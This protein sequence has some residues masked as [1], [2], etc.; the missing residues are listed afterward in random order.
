MAIS[1][2]TRRQ[3][4]GLIEEDYIR[5][6]IRCPV[7]GRK[8]SHK[9]L[10]NNTACVDVVCMEYQTTSQVKT[11]SLAK[12]LRLPATVLG[13]SWKAKK[14]FLLEE[15]FHPYFFVFVTSGTVFGVCYLPSACQ[16]LDFLRYASRFQ[17]RLSRR[18]G[19]VNN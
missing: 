16:T 19:L 5:N 2:P 14:K 17:I 12:S 15:V 18:A 3:S 7:C 4:L 10:A 9:L 1:I 8:G 11:I 6:Q 13:G